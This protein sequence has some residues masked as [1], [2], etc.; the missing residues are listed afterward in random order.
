[1][2]SRKTSKNR[3]R[4]GLPV[5]RRARGWRLAPRTAA[6]PAHVHQRLAQ[7]PLEQGPLTEDQARALFLVLAGEPVAEDDPGLAALRDDGLLT[8]ADRDGVCADLALA[9][10]SATS[11]EETAPDGKPQA[12]TATPECHNDYLE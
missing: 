1:V 12:R 11:D 6:L 2:F 4:R 9:L 7:V 5:R 10:D 8:T 3:P